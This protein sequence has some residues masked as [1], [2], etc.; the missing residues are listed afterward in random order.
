MY[1]Q[2]AEDN[3]LSRRK[4][5]KR[6]PAAAVLLAP[7]RALFLAMLDFNIDGLATKLARRNFSELRSFWLNAGG[8]PDKLAKN[9]NKGKGKKPKKIGFIKKFKKNG[10]LAEMENPFLSYSGCAPGYYQ[11]ASG[12]CIKSKSGMSDY[13]PSYYLSEDLSDQKKAAIIAA[14][15]TAGTLIGTAVPGIGNVAGAAAGASLGQVIIKI[16]P[17]IKQAADD[18]A[19]DEEV[20]PPATPSV[21]ENTGTDDEETTMTGKLPK[22]ALPIG[23]GIVGLGLIYYFTKKK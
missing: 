9:I 6:N 16:Y 3:T 1:L 23:A 20:A 15:T 22:W 19:G 21:P 11:T 7:G 14:S 4:K 8:D 10:Q 12:S 2:L 13:G 5:D 18:T 17:M